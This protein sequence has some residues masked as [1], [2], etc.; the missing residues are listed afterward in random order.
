MFATFDIC[1]KHTKLSVGGESYSQR[2]E[3]TDLVE[4][5]RML[6]DITHWSLRLQLHVGYMGINQTP[7]SLHG[8]TKIICY[9]PSGFLKLCFTQGKLWRMHE[10][11]PVDKNLEALNFHHPKMRDTIIIILALVEVVQVKLSLM[12]SLAF[13]PFLC[14]HYE[15]LKCH[16]SVLCSFND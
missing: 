9:L 14:F 5:G 11:Q 15:E 16:E 6:T 3:Y 8:D 4:H 2:Y 10:H 7:Q 13:Q 12:T 1:W